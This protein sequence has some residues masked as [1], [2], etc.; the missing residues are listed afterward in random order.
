MV[1][2]MVDEYG[3]EFEL[4]TRKVSVP[5]TAEE[6]LVIFRDSNRHPLTHHARFGS[7]LFSILIL[8]HWLS[9]WRSSPRQSKPDGTTFTNIRA[10]ILPHH[11]LV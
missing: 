10:W 8:T 9:Q 7:V 3:T 5:L 1:L 11:P 6:V 2:S 4:P